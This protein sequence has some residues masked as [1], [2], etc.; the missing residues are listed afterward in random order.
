ML[1]A[2]PG[3]ELFLSGRSF[4][5]VPVKDLEVCAQ[6]YD[7]QVRFPQG[8]FAQRVELLE[9]KSTTVSARPKPRLTYAGFEGDE[10]IRRPG[11]DH[12]PAG[13]PGLAPEPG[14]LPHRRQG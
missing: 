7:L 4:G 10:P 12:R 2:A 6:A 13:D 5:P 3:G 1:S 9:G 8:A 14:R 11:A